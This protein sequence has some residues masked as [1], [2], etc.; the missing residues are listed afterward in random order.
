MRPPVP[1]L[2]DSRQDRAKLWRPRPESNRGARICN[3]HGI[4]SNQ[5]LS[6]KRPRFQAPANQRVGGVLQN[7]GALPSADRAVASARRR[8]LAFFAGRPG[9]RSFVLY[10]QAH[11]A[12]HLFGTISAVSIA[13]FLAS[14]NTALA[15]SAI[16]LMVLCGGYSRMNMIGFV[17]S[18][19][20]VCLFRSRSP[21][22]SPHA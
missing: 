21:L 19:R 1:A 4:Q 7:A 2:C 5:R 17:S 15:M 8:V 3:P 22:L 11:M 16:V 13:V 10:A 6:C 18:N 14:G 9:G 20:E 12:V